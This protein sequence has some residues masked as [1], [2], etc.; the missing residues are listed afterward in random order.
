MLSPPQADALRAAF[1]IFHQTESL[2]L[3]QWAELHFELA[4]GSSQSTGPWKCYGY[5]RGIMDLISNDSVE[6]LTIQKSARVG[7]SKMLVAALGY[8]AQY[9]QRN[10][11]IW[12]PN[13]EAM[14]IFAQTEIEPLLRDMKIMRSV[15]P[16][17][18]TRSDNKNSRLVQFTSTTLHTRGGKSQN[19]FASITVAAAW[20]DEVEKFDLKIGKAG[21]PLVLARKRL[22]GATYPKMV[23]GSTPLEK[24]GSI[25]EAQRLAAEI[26]LRYHIACPHCGEDHP[27]V[28]G[29]PGAAYGL[30]WTK[31]HPEGVR[32]VCPHCGA[33]IAQADYLACADVGRWK[34]QAGTWLDDAGRFRSASGSVLRTPASVGVHIWSAYSPQ[35][36]W[37]RIAR[38]FVEAEAA[39]QVGRAGPMISFTNETLGLTWETPADRVEVEALKQRAG[40][41]QLRMVPDEV[42]GIVVGVD[43]QDNRFELVAWGYGRGEESWLIDYAVLHGDPGRKSTW[44]LLDGYRATRFERIGGGTIGIDGMAIDTGGHFTHQAYNYCRMRKSQNIFAV[45]GNRQD[46]QAIHGKSNLIDVNWS[47]RIL[48]GGVR[49]YFV[50]T[51][52]AK[53]L[54]HARLRIAAPGPG[55][56]HFPEDLPE[57]FWPGFAS[58]ARMLQKTSSG[59]RFRWTKV[60]LRN[61]PL[62]CT[63][64]AMFTA[65]ALNW[66]TFTDSMWSQKAARMLNAAGQITPPAGAPTVRPIQPPAPARRPAAPNPFASDAWSSRL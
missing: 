16:V 17:Y 31:G 65:H 66:D 62:D 15:F 9:K 50:G 10:Q 51:D 64:Y 37:V 47:G 45:A 27:L 53:D 38:D 52:T 5:Q 24:V 59:E 20:L 43:T 13:D 39:A 61:E 14:R 32:H 46:G 8:F 3:S 34:S 54:L 1:A 7:Y 30:T 44:D 28:W 42:L 57:E 49:L 25:V 21:D 23:V 29:G 48:K 36:T 22:E 63:V 6:Q 11:S 18:R 55:Y 19:N 2:T 60:E 4:P 33:E 56:V 35:T 12:Q 40:G 58:E 41:Y 26:D